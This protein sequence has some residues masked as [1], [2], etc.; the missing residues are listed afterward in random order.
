[1]RTQGTSVDHRTVAVVP[2]VVCNHPDDVAEVQVV[3]DY[4]I[5]VRFHDGTHGIVDLARLIHSH[6]RATGTWVLE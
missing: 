5:A 6:V 2:R 4:R 1:M 3:G